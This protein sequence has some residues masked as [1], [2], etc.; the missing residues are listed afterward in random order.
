MT[1][2]HY[3]SFSFRNRRG[4]PDILRRVSMW[5]MMLLRGALAGFILAILGFATSSA[6]AIVL[7]IFLALVAVLL[8]MVSAWCV[9][10]MGDATGTR[11]VLGMT[12]VSFVPVFGMVSAWSLR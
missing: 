4:A 12:I 1:L 9:A 10:L 2:R 6:G 8:L 11:R 3:R 5:L 7:V